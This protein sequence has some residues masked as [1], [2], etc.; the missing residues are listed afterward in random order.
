MR[1]EPDVITE[2]EIQSILRVV[3]RCQRY[4]QFENRHIKEALLV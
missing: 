4:L 2:K 1:H 3:D